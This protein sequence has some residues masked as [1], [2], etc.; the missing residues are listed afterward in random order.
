M[1]IET[2][3]RVLTWNDD[4]AVLERVHD[5][6]IALLCDRLGITLGLI[7]QADAAL[8]AELAADVRRL[9]DE[10]LLRLVAAPETSYRL[11]WPR[12]HRTGDVAAFLRGAVTAELARLERVLPVPTATWTA[13][14]DMRFSP[15]GGVFAAPRVDGLLTVD[16]DS[17]YALHVD[18]DGMLE[19]SPVP[20]EPLSH[21][22]KDVTLTRLR[23]AKDGIEQTNPIIL[24]VVNIFTKALVVQRDSVAPR[25][26][27]SGSSAQYVG[28]SVLA[29]AHIETV[30]EIEVAEGLVHEAIH[31]LLYM[32]EQQRDWVTSDELY[33]PQQRT[34]SLWTGNPLPLRS[35]LQACFVW[36]GLLCFW[37]QALPSGA[38]DAARV[39]E[40]IMQAAR[41]FLGVP[42][43]AQVAPYRSQIAPDVVG[44]IELIQDH[45]Q[46]SLSD[47]A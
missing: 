47:L 6:Y 45:V 17:P 2:M 22:E 37:T 9:P 29:N 40:R 30:S 38:F 15:D 33:G 25:L 5:A 14:G 16:F 26:F 43:L 1:L 3:P 44:A 21:D 36:Y 4:R 12:R 11:L 8:G 35:Y 31:S 34:V 7:S 46:A 10:A 19:V 18:L 32:Q 42:V 23:V 28:R 13:R 27:S 41:G 24:D 20:R 39:K